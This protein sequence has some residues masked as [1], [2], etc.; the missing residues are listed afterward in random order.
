MLKK[1]IVVQN[2]SYYDEAFGFWLWFL[3]SKVLLCCSV[4]FSA[5]IKGALE[6]VVNVSEEPTL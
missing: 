6:N 3:P 4:A 1:N 2:G 5:V